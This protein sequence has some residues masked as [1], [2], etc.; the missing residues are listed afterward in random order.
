[1]SSSKPMK[2]DES[3]DILQDRAQRVFDSYNIQEAESDE[4]FWAAAWLRAECHCEHQTSARYVESTKKKFAEEEFVA[5]KRRQLGKYGH[6]IKSLC[7]MAIRRESLHNNIL[8]EH[9][10]TLLENVIGTLDITV[11]QLMHGEAFPGDITRSSLSVGVSALQRPHRYGYIANMCV[12]K[13]SR[14]KGIASSLV[15]VAIEAG[16]DWGLKEIYVHVYP[17]NIAGQ[18]LYIKSGFQMVQTNFN[19]TKPEDVQLLRLVL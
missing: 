12:T 6:S 2:L 3:H 4:E 14:N 10:G 15:Q 16:K 5:V 11:R 19:Q 9:H 7:F 1:M 18:R 8:Q 17:S 13:T